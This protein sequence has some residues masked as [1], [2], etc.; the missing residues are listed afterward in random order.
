MEYGEHI[1]KLKQRKPTNMQQQTHNNREF[2]DKLN[3]RSQNQFEP[4]DPET[5]RELKRGRKLAK[6]ARK[7][8]TQRHLDKFSLKAV[9]PL[10]EN[11]TRTFE[12]FR[13]EKHLLLH[14][15]AGT[16]KTFVSISL[17][18]E[19]IFADKGSKF[20][21]IVVVR[22]VVPSRDMGY[23]PGSV[24]EKIRAYEE[25]YEEICNELF[26]QGNTGYNMLKDRGL[27]EF[28]TT[29]FLRGVTFMDAIIIV[30]EI[31]NMTF[32]EL[33]TVITRLGD[34]CRIIFCGDFRQTDLEKDSDKNGLHQFM[35]IIHNLPNFEYVEFGREDIV[36]SAL[37]KEYI[38]AR[39][40][41]VD[42]PKPISITRMHDPMSSDWFNKS[43]YDMVI[44]HTPIGGTRTYTEGNGPGHVMSFDPTKIHLTP[45][46]KEKVVT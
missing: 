8:E 5:R 6:R 40:E 18:L 9:V 39:T 10:T 12:A 19:N 23:L 36:R 16:G 38:I 25:P 34:N 28:T 11:Q 7:M 1:S 14:G 45:T 32:Q 15:Y 44:M 20:K 3:E 26:G 30:D 37:V 31:Q 42:T 4:L 22:S 2:F 29:S 35:K 24:T 13:A 33:D 27:F 41:E 46:D 17:A 43:L 21:K